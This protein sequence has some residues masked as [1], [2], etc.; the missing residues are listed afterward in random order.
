MH[1]AT[2]RIL[3]VIL[4]NIEGF[5]LGN[6]SVLVCATNRKQDLDAALLS[7]FDTC[8]K[9]DLPS[10]SARTKIFARCVCMDGCM[11]GC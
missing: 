1:E 6:K 10:T 7:R 2:R 9:F 3:S 4:Q 5:K 8:I 11:Y